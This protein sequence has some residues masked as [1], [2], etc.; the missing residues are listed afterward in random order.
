MNF[1]DTLTEGVSL[2]L[3]TLATGYTPVGLIGDKVFPRVKSLLS[4]G[5]IPQYGKDSFR[6]Y[7]SI[8]AVSARSNRISQSPI[9]WL[10]F[11]CQEHD[12]VVPLDAQQLEEL[13]KIPG[14][15][16]LVA[17][18]DLQNRARITL[19]QNMANDLEKVVADKVQFSGNYVDG[20]SRTLATTLCWSEHETSQPVEDIEAG[21][22]KVRSLIG[23]RP[24]TLVLGQVTWDV[25]KFHT[26]YASLYSA[27]IDK[28]LTPEMLAKFHNL[29]RIIIG[30]SVYTPTNGGPITDIWGDFALLC[31]IPDTVTP[32][33]E[34]PG[35]GYTI[36]PAYAT[37]PY[38]YVDTFVEEGGKIINVRVT[39]KWDTLFTMSQ[40][41]YLIKNTVK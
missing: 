19:Q 16:Q 5:T 35:F 34:E 31:Y 12:L 29:K 37:T 27:N 28:I 2:P 8:R 41:G 40:A 7:D 3:S 23:R 4:H 30:E 15:L 9:S 20:N 38:P 24:N 18:F 25:L 32:S 26:E 1:F 33:Y 13:K 10:N 6:I 36:V 21:I 17:M 11:N 39:D 22:A 14:D